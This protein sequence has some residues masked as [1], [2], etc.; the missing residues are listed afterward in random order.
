MSL[1]AREWAKDQRARKATQLERGVLVTLTP[2]ERFLLIT[3]ADFE[4][5]EE[6]YAYPS[7]AT[8][9]EETGFNKRTVTRLLG[10]LEDG[11]LIIR[12]K[13]RAAGKRWGNTHYTFP[14]AAEYRQKDHAWLSAHGMKAR[15]R[16]G[17]PKADPNAWMNSSY[18]EAIHGPRDPEERVRLLA[19]G[20][21]PY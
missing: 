5:V 6:G 1:S 20:S 14:V 10:K 19:S 7:L 21:N 3:L 16:G 11:G 13:H 8:L 12:V 9:V 18:S 17:R 15:P 2:S 4:S